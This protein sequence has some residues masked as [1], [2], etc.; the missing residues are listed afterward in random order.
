MVRRL[1][2][3]A[4]TIH[5]LG[6]EK[7]PLESGQTGQYTFKKGVSEENQSETRVEIAELVE[8]LERRA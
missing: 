6:E 7:N 3:A 8:R 1:V 2:A 4:T 5:V